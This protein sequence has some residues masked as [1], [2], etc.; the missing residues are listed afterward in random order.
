MET[1]SVA[2]LSWEEAK[3]SGRTVLEIAGAGK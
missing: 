3:G 2:L 1:K